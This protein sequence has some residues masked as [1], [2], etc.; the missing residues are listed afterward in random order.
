MNVEPRQP[1]R[2]RSLRHVWAM[3][4]WTV[5]VTAIGAIVGAGAALWALSALHVVGAIAVFVAAVQTARSLLL[6]L[7]ISRFRLWIPGARARNQWA[8]SPS[9]PHSYRVF[10]LWPLGR[11]RTLGDRPGQSA[12]FEAWL[13]HQGA[14]RDA[15]HGALALAAQ[16]LGLCVIV[17]GIAGLLLALPSEWAY[18]RYAIVAIVFVLS[19]AVLDSAIRWTC[20]SA[21]GHQLHRQ[22]GFL[23]RFRDLPFNP[24]TC[25]WSA[26]DIAPDPPR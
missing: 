14:H 21:V 10:A 23:G 20:D 1:F 19:S 13:R 24:P 12:A 6:L 2:P 8:S 22:P 26:V 11:L 15:H 3:D 17:A 16:T 25:A 5:V 9:E 7:V 18:G 4:L